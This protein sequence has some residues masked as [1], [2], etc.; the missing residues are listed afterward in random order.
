M[1]SNE[2]IARKGLEYLT[3][4]GATDG[5]CVTSVGTKTEFYYESGKLG[6]LRTVQNMTVSLK[7]LVGTRKGT[8]SINSFDDGEL[9]RAAFEAVESAKI[10]KEDPAEGLAEEIVVKSFEQGPLTPDPEVMLTRITG[11]FDELKEKY[12][13]V[14]VDSASIDHTVSE[15]VYC[16]TNG[17]CFHSRRGL[18]SFSPMFMCRDGENTSSFNYFGALFEDPDTSL[19]DLA[20]GRGIIESSLKQITP[21]AFRGKFEGD[22]IFTPSCFGSLLGAVEGNFLSDGA[23]ME[24][25]SIWKDQIGKQV[26]AESFKWS[27]CPRSEELAGGYFT[28]AD[29]YEARNMDIIKGGVL[30]NFVLG[31]YASKKTGLSRSVSGGGCYIVDGGDVSLQEMISSVKHGLLV[32]R[33]SGGSPSSDGTLSGIAKNSFEIRDGKIC[34]AVNEVMI[35]GNLAQ[36]LKD[37]TQI[38][39]ERINDGDSCLPWI[40]IRNITVSGQ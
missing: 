27:S 39:S 25:T 18:Y 35:S 32:G 4:A 7:A 9:K 20:G 24:G 21:T 38:S 26:A 17:I 8:A 34:D 1:N 36:M 19:M 28:T 12:P 11:F 29:G 10:S 33:F 23:L 3:A 30:Q 13:A 37:I 15:S 16:T 31:R 14:S 22:V 2:T 6:M 40:K 5:V